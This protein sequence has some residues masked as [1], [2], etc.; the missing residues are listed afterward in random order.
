MELIPAPEHQDPNAFVSGKAAK[1]LLNSDVSAA[2]AHARK[3]LE[4]DPADSDAA[5]LLG[6]ALRRQG[7]FDKARTFLEPLTH[8]QPQMGPAW[9]ELGQTLA[10]CGEREKAVEA[11]LR[12][13]DLDYLDREAW[14]ALGDLLVFPQSAQAAAAGVHPQLAAAEAALREHHSETADDILRRLL[15]ANPENVRALKL[16]AEVA[17]RTERWDEFEALMEKCLQLAPDFLAARFRYVTMRFAHRDVRG[18]LPHIDKLLESDQRNVLY[19]SLKALAL[20]AGRQFDSAIGE[21]EAL[22]DECGHRP[23]LWLEYA[24][25]LQASRKKNATDVC[26]KAIELLPS[27]VEAYVSIANAKS[28]RMDEAMIDRLRALL[29]R[30]GLPAE[31]RAKL[32]YA[33]GKAF[34]D[35]ERYA[36]SF[37]NYRTSNVILR[38]AGASGI[39]D[40]NLYLRHAKAL[41]TPAFFRARSSFGCPQPDPVFI[42]GMPRAGSTLVEQIL[43][44]HSAVEALGELTDLAEIGQRVAPDRPD[45]PQGGYPH[46]LKGLGAERFRVLGEEYMKATRSRRKL[47]RPFFTDKMPGNFFHVGLI[48]LAL[49]NAKIIDVRRHPLDCCFSCFKHHFQAGHSYARELNDVGRFYANYVELMAHFDEVL[50][51]R[52]F[53]IV[54]EDLIG[55]FEAEV[56]LLLDHL[57][58]PFE[59]QCLRFHENERLVQ[60]LSADQVSRPLYRTAVGHWRHFEQWLDPLK[61]SLGYVLD[62]Y[63]QV[64]KF[65]SGVHAES[66]SPR[67]LGPASRRFSF[68]KGVRQVAFETEPQSRALSES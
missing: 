34:E 30:P 15:E 39:A 35:L 5:Y 33:M 4:T 47:N 31:D 27:F 23:G 40:S 6:A 13:L 19:R 55:N 42:V 1:N 52:V 65:Y 44:S 11:V 17:L 10:A 62:T 63:P 26:K 24:R 32:H 49:P 41:F 9:Y 2:E 37:D 14:F 68:V 22:I 60:T 58:L 45:L 54:Y 67:S 59:E 29:V 8:S 21:F 16:L 12:A 66:K 7:L 48:H 50:P 28:F 3:Y 46:V 51:G 57:G 38:G 25:V 53:R 20:G 18:L 61:L 43:S 36:E 64:P 56:R